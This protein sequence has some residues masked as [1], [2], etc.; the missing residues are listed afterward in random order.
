MESLNDLIWNDEEDAEPYL[1]EKPMWKIC[2]TI[3]K[4]LCGGSGNPSLPCSSTLTPCMTP[5]DMCWG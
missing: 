3:P 2:M 4:E 5:G 1:I